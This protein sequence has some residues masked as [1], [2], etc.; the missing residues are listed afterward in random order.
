MSVR[1]FRERISIKDVAREAGTSISTVSR[2]LNNHPDVSEET[3]DRILAIA[4]A[5]GYERNVLAHSLISGRSG[6]ISVIIPDINYDYELQFLRGMTHAA[7]RLDQEL[8]LT[9]RDSAAGTIEACRSMYQRGLTDGAVVFQ[10]PVEGTAEFLELQKAGF[11]LVAFHPP[12]PIQGLTS[13]E[14]MDYEGGLLAVQ[15]LLSW[16]HRRIGIIVED[17]H[18]TAGRE[19]LRGYQDALQ[20]A[21]IHLDPQLLKVVPSNQPQRSGRA[22]IRQ[23]IE[24]KVD[25]TA[26][27]CFN[28]LVA[29]GAIEELVT[30]GRRVPEDV[31]IVGF[32][33]I[34]TSPHFGWRGLTTIKQPITRIGELA[35]E[36]LLQLCD[37]KV[38]PGQ[39]ILVPVELVVRGTTA[40]LEVPGR[41]ATLQAEAAT[42][43][44]P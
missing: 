25:F 4:Q 33:D 20:H 35:L 42:T 39:R 40:P 13:V 37:G 23:W 9:V 6:L 12:Q 44:R 41:E 21:G 11:P 2:A 15:H 1:D 10:P 28:D 31:S 43:G 36:T 17:P 7:R 18:R 34:P 22:A 19:R 32:D 3:R 26:V 8:L 14:P 5:Q 29:Y 27:F 24:S 30:Y 16:G 38:E